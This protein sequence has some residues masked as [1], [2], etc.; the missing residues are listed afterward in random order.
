MERDLDL[1]THTREDHS[2]SSVNLLSLF[3]FLLS[4]LLQS[5][6]GKL[7]VKHE[8]VVLEKVVEDVIDL[9]QPLVSLC[10]F[11]VFDPGQ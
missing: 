6:Q 2:C 7:V 9:C 5:L 11:W 3:P 10:L 8:K 1:A 4:P